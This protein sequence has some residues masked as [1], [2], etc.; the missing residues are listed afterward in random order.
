MHGLLPRRRFIKCHCWLSADILG[1]CGK[2]VE[3]SRGGNEGGRTGNKESEIYYF[4][5]SRDSECVQSVIFCCCVKIVV[6][7]REEIRLCDFRDGGHIQ[8]HL[9]Q[10]GRC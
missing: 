10:R 3:L 8:E 2:S 6:G 5:V 7:G 1:Y 9:A 4:G